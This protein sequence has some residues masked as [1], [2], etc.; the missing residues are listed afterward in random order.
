M[1]YKLAFVRRIGYFMG[2]R[3][4][5]SLK[6]EP[7]SKQK[8]EELMKQIRDFKLPFN[9]DVFKKGNGNVLVDW[10][11]LVEMD[12]TAREGTQSE[13]VLYG[14]YD[15]LLELGVL[16]LNGKG[17]FQIIGGGVLLNPRS[18][19]LMPLYFTKKEDASAYKKVKCEKAHYDVNISKICT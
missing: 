3:T 11:K 17:N 10:A 19:G 7:L 12:R 15:H 1:V 5:D 13:T 8:K 14:T 6:T 9:E 16:S 2:Y 18:H 4:C